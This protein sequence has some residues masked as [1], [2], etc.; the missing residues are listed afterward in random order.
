MEAFI[1]LINAT[2]LTILYRL[3][4]LCGNYSKVLILYE[5]STIP[6]LEPIV[7]SSSDY[8]S[9][10]GNIDLA[11]PY[12]DYDKI[13]FD[14]NSLI[15]FLFDKDVVMKATKLEMRYGYKPYCHFLFV[16]S[17][18][19]ESGL[20]GR[21]MIPARQSTIDHFGLILINANGSF[22]LF[23]IIHDSQL[24]VKILNI[25]NKGCSI[26]NKMFY[27]KIKD[28]KGENQYVFIALDPPRAINVT[29]E[30][31]YGNQVISMGGTAAY[32]A[33]LI[34]TKVNITVK[35]WTIRISTF[36]YNSHNSEINHAYYEF[37]KDFTE[38]TYEDDNLTP[39][40]LECITLGSS[41]D[42]SKLY[43]KI[44]DFYKTLL[45]IN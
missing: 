10:V 12:D 28:F 32:L 15:I 14:Y 33:S 41:K 23:H 8:S 17:D 19:N 35:L 34:P 5:N 36:G 13:H 37:L 29:S 11:P 27:S 24:V 40:Q 16:S 22:A 38:R 39:K 42:V 25:P 26:Y 20:N 3:L 43:V 4:L 1:S 30:N 18:N 44:I 6:I 31:E 45:I 2:Q 9:V 7:I 21:F